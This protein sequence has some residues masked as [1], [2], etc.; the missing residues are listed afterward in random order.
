MK[1]SELKKYLTWNVI[2]GIG[3]FCTIIAIIFWIWINIASSGLNIREDIDEY[4]SKYIMN[5]FVKPYFELFLYQLFF[6]IILIIG[7]KFEKKHYIENGEEGLMLF[8][9]YDKIYSRVFCAG[10]LLNF[11]PFFILLIIMI[12]YILKHI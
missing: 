11:V 4:F 1:I 12:G 9:N 10:I 5:F 8:E 6:I 2:S 3:F 7:T